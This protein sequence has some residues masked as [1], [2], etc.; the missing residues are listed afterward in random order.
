MP[1]AQDVQER[2]PSY[3]PL[4]T[5]SSTTEDTTFMSVRSADGSISQYDQPGA[6]FDW[7]GVSEA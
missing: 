5:R 1:Q 6:V 2:R 3:T 4:L 7:S